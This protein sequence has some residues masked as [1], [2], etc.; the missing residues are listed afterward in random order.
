VERLVAE[1]PHNC[2]PFGEPRHG[3]TQ[4]CERPPDVPPPL[5]V[6]EATGGPA[7]PAT[8]MLTASLYAILWHLVEILQ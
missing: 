3:P 8:C 4:P 2:G 6:G 1:S 5:T 7:R